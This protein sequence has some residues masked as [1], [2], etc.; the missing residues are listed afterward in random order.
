M[1]Q[2][3]HIF[4]IGHY[5]YL[6]VLY[7]FIFPFIVYLYCFFHLF[8]LSPL[9]HRLFSLI[10]LLNIYF[11][12]IFCY[13][14]FFSPFIFIVSCLL[15]RYGPATYVLCGE[16]LY[17]AIRHLPWSLVFQSL[18]ANSVYRIFI[19]PFTVV[20][21]FISFFLNSYISRTAFVRVIFRADFQLESW[22]SQ[23]YAGL[24]RDFPSL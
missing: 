17:P 19:T 13:L 20:N 3:K 22:L 2:L 6:L 23:F 15:S 18:S 24:R 8:T 1:Q 21:L 4:P 9:R 14:F 10:L 16:R 12:S 11:S 7:S 5:F